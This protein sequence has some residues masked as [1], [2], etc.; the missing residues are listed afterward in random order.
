MRIRLVLFA[1]RWARDR[2]GGRIDAARRRSRGDPAARP[3]RAACCRPARAASC[4]RPGSPAGTGSPHLNDQ[5]ELFLASASSPPCSTGPASEETPR[6]GVTDRARRL[7][8]AG[9]PAAER[10]TTPGGASAT[11]SPRTGCSSSSCSAAPPAAAWRRSS[12]TSYLDDDLIARRDYYTDAELDADDRRAPAELRAR[13]EAYRDGINAWVAE[14]RSDPTQAARAS[15]RRWACRRRLDAARHRPRSA[16]S[17]PAPCPRATTATS[18]RTP[19]R[20][21]R[22]GRTAFDQLLPLRTQGA[23]PTRAAR[24]RAC[25]RRSRAARASRSARAF[26]ARSGSSRGA[27]A[28]GPPT[29]PAAAR[30]ARRARAAI[31]APGSARTRRLVHVARSAAAEAAPARLPVQRP[32]ARLL[33]PRAVR[34]VRAALARARTSAASARAGRAGAGHRPQRA[35][36]LGLHLAASPTRTTST[37]R[38]STGARDATASRA[39]TRQMD[40]RDER[41]DF[42]APADRPARPRRRPG[43]LSGSS[44]RAHLPHRPRAGAGA[45]R[46]RRLRAPLRDLGPRAGDARRAST[47]LND[48]Q[49]GARRRPRDAQVTWNENVIA[50]DDRGNI[51]YWHPGPAPAAAAAATTSGCPTP[52][53][54][55][56]S[57]AAC[58]RARATPHVINP[59]AGLA[60]STGTTC[61]SPGWTTGDSEARERLAGPF[62][63]VALLQRAGA[64]AV[65]ARAG[66]TSARSAIDRTTRAPPPSSARCP[67]RS[68]AARAKG[69]TGQAQRRARRAARAGTATTRAPTPTA[70]STR[71]S[72]SGRSSRTGDDAIA[73]ARPRPER[74][75]SRCA[76]GDR[77][78]AR[79]STSPTARPSRCARWRAPA[80]RRPPSGTHAA[81]AKRFGTPTPTPGASR[82]ACTRSSAQG[83]GSL[84]GPAVLRPRHLAAARGDGALAGQRRRTASTPAGTVGLVRLDRT[85]SPCAS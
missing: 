43:R 76:G 32:A 47:A 51:G 50:A 57:G 23:V 73:L 14:V 6:A 54:A 75:S 25:S 10:L 66:A 45:R 1:P 62:H 22:S 69:A 67:A 15:S 78:L 12:A 70:P 2:R 38:S 13:A 20:S 42:R 7:R 48:A 80:L 9:D 63:R 53:P 18:S 46:R 36:R 74:G 29:A 11:R 3:R 41:F 37:P 5:M 40:C 31:V 68:C 85:G 24:A 30:R 33:D 28:A 61:P 72:R 65:A 71:A 39:Q 52:A 19:A 8:R 84:P 16:S 44:T 59:R 34:G 27:A 4:L 56:P 77:Q 35:R 17:S 60:R 79:S 49:D 82:G 21:R 58:C 26:G 64:R 55:R 83:A 81:L